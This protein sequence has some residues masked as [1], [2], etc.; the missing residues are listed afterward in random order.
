MKAVLALVSLVVTV[1]SFFIFQSYDYGWFLY[2]GILGLIS[3]IV[4][5]GIYMSGR[6]N[7]DGDLHITN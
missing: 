6:V 2:V 3:T 5:G 1:V 4:F 7:K